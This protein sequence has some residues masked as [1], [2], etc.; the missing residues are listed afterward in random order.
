[1]EA[2]MSLKVS[3]FDEYRIAIL[4]P[5]GALPGG[6][7]TDELRSAAKELLDKGFKK[8]IVDLGNVEYINSPGIGALVSI[9]TTFT[10]SG[11]R[12]KLCNLGKRVKN[13]FVITKLITVMDSEETREAALASFSSSS[14]SS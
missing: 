2:G 1:M 13:V 4:E 9:H 10:G 5:N 11:G 14:S 12:M 7:E 6:K 8:L 3:Q